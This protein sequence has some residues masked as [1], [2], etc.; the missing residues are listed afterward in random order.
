[1]SVYESLFEYKAMWTANAVTMP[2]NDN[3]IIIK[4]GMNPYETKLAIFNSVTI[5][6]RY[7]S[8]MFAEVIQ[9]VYL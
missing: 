3:V 1:M 7:L 8:W 2:T 9:H 6:Q 4:I 5:I